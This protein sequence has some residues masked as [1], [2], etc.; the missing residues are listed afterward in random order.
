MHLVALVETRHVSR[1]H[2]RIGG[3]AVLGDEGEVEA[4]LGRLREGLEDE[5]VGV[6]AAD[7]NEPLPVA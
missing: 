4:G 2:A 3:L 6:A 7:Q 5:Q 1:Q